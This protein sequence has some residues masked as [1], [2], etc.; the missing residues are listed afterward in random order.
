MRDLVRCLVHMAGEMWKAP[1]DQAIEQLT[2]LAV[3]IIGVRI[4]WKK[5]WK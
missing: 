3:I 4:L 5:V 1:A 2:W